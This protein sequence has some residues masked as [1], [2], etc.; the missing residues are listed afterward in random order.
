MTTITTI[1]GSTSIPTDA[2]WNVPVAR[3][4]VPPAR[5][6]HAAATNSPIFSHECHQGFCTVCGSVW[7][8]S[9]AAKWTA[10]QT[11]PIPRQDALGR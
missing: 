3:R 10:R 11:P 9:R 4:S 2:P 1:T 5:A 7:P 8:C 6:A